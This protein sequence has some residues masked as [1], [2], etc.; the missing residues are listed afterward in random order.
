[1][2]LR[3]SSPQREFQLAD[4]AAGA[5]FAQSGGQSAGLALSGW[6]HS[7]VCLSPGELAIPSREWPGRGAA[8][9]YHEFVAS[10]EYTF[11]SR[12]NADRLGDVV[13]DSGRRRRGGRRR[14]RGLVLDK[15]SRIKTDYQFIEG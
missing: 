13:N 6:S 15:D 2:P 5:P 12:D 9:T 10:G 14:L 7:R 1:V 11:R 8:R 3:G 4:P